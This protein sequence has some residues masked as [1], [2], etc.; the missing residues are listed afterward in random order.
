MHTVALK[1]RYD[2]G[3]D[4]PRRRDIRSG[5]RCIARQPFGQAAAVERR[6]SLRAGHQGGIIIGDGG[7]RILHPEI[8]E[9]AVRESIAIARMQAQRFIAIR[10]SLFQ[11]AD[12]RS[13]FAAG[14]PVNG[15]FRLDLACAIQIGDGAVGSNSALGYVVGKKLLNFARAA[16]DHPE[17]ASE[18]L[19]SFPRSGASTALPTDPMPVFRVELHRCRHRSAAAFDPTR[20][21]MTVQSTASQAWSSRLSATSYRRG[22]RQIASAPWPSP[23]MRIAHS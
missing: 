2:L 9:A 17:F 1:L 4:L 6:G 13:L 14:V 5:A 21:V 3:I 12:N 11:V 18:L 16:V 7:L 20:Q 22:R 10:E 8:G 19:S 23:S 15:I